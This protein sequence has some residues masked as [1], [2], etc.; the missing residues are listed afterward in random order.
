MKRLI[1]PVAVTLASSIVLAVLVVTDQLLSLPVFVAAALLLGTII[2]VWQLTVRG[3]LTLGT[4]DE[5]AWAILLGHT[6][7]VAR[8][9]DAA[10]LAHSNALTPHIAVET[11]IWL[12][13]LAYSVIR[14]AGTARILSN[15]VGTG[16]RY[17]TLL[18]ILALLS[19]LYASSVMITLAWSLKLFTIL[20]MSAVLVSRESPAEAAAAFLRGTKAGLLL[21]V[22]SFLVMAAASPE[23]AMDHSNATGIVRIGGYLLPSTQ[24]STVTGL[25]LVLYILAAFVDGWTKTRVSVMAVSFALLLGSIGRA[26]MLAA[27][28]TSSVLLLRFHRVRILAALLSVA[29]L[30]VTAFPMMYTSTW[31]YLSRKQDVDGLTSLTGRIPLWQASIPLILERPLLGWGY[32]SGGRVKFLN[33]F[34]W[35]TAPHTHNFV[36]E[37]LLD[38]GILGAVLLLL[39]LLHTLITTWK[40]SSTRWSP[41]L[42]A[43]LQQD[44]LA[45]F[46]CVVFLVVDGMFTAGVSGAPR[47]ETV[48]LFG[49]LFVSDSLAR[50]TPGPA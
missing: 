6:V 24:L 28:L 41:R 22:F 4:M 39:I 9:R 33:T 38:L 5:I 43:T 14:I 10:E 2:F 27:A 18:A 20:L 48:I 30:L 47:F 37:M 36:I 3:M 23:A 8:V 34:N 11:S 25:L 46:C 42:P 21:L 50:A 12:V 44:S 32:V 19:A 1:G 45:V 29:A 16:A 13:I 17:G 15:L 35:W 26:G 49:A 7:V 40:R 31:D